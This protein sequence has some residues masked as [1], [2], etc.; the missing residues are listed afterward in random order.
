M[1][2]KGNYNNKKKTK[3]YHVRFIPDD[4]YPTFISH[5]VFFF[6]YLYNILIQLFIRIIN[7]IVWFGYYNLYN[8]INT[9]EYPFFIFKR[10]KLDD[11]L[12]VLLHKL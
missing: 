7:D 3:N 1:K 4:V 11:L 6:E 8:N 12:R 5:S 10:N 9:Q 2:I